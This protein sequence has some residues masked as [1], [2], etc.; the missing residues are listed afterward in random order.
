L[1][2]PVDRTTQSSY[3]KF[4]KQL[5]SH[6]R[7]IKQQRKQRKLAPV[8]VTDV[9]SKFVPAL[10]YFHC[11]SK[12]KVGKISVKQ[13]HDYLMYF[14]NFLLSNHNLLIDFA[15]YSIWSDGC[16]KHFKTYTSQFYISQFQ[17]QLETKITWDFLPP[18]DAHNRA[19]AQAGSF[20]QIIK[21]AVS[22]T[23]ILNEIEHLMAISSHMKNCYKFEASIFLRS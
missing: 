12:K 19:D 21:R 11:V 14:L 8:G 17:L 13:T 20:A 5:T 6:V 7:S 4:P 2:S 3:A 15:N 10:T 16:G 9:N 22:N 18:H 1:I 23:F